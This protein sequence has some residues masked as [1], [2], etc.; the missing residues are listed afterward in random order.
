M[1]VLLYILILGLM[2]FAPVER[3]DVAQL[4][5]IE[6]VAMYMDGNL[7]VLETDTQ[8]IG[9]GENAASALKNLKDV[10]PAVVYLDT[11]QYL[12][13]DKEA[14]AYID[15]L[16]EHLK[17]SVDVTVC[18]ARGKVKEMAEFVSVHG[19]CIPL[20]DW[21]TKNLEKTS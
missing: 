13:V 6:A 18:D 4:L 20:K 9:R 21:K 10:T 19:E 12:L 15:E 8:N 14:E 3:V 7:V 2:F 16:R 1:R 5:P 17:S 11:A